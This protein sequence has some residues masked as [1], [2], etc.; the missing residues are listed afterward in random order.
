CSV[1]DES[2]RIFVAGRLNDYT[3]GQIKLAGE[4]EIA[5]IVRWHRLNRAGPITYQNVIGDPDG[6]LFLVRRIN[7]EGAGKNAGL[8]LRQIGSLEFAFAR[9]TLEIF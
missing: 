7:R 3:N 8:F 9:C 4:L 5:L 1:A 6:N 2:Y